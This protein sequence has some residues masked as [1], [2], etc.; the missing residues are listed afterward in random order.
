VLLAYWNTFD[1][2]SRDS[3]QVIAP[4]TVSCAEV[5]TN[6]SGNNFIMTCGVNGNDPWITCTGGR[7]AVI[8]L[9]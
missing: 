4:G 3:R 9:Y 8:Y 1:S 6:C 2:P 7:D 5:S